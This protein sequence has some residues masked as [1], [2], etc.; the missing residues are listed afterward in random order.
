MY[1]SGMSS[2]SPAKAAPADDHL[3]PARALVL[4]AYY[5]LRQVQPGTTIGSGE[6]R[7]WIR[8]QKGS[9]EL[10]SDSLIV[11]TLAEAGVPR[12]G[13]GRPRRDEAVD[14][15]PAAPPFVPVRRNPP[16]P[17]RSR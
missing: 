10:P 16:K 13:T 8:R 12:R 15:A 7:R 9:G 4:E 2:E 11:L 6:I 1:A 14:A 17:S 5:A 3:T